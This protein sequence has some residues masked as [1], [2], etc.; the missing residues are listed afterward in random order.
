MR[1]T[2]KLLDTQYRDHRADLREMTNRFVDAIDR[3]SVNYQNFTLKAE[4][5]DEKLVEV[6]EKIL[7]RVGENI[8]VSELID[9]KVDNLYKIILQKKIK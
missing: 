7:K 5:R 9:H 4:A 1:K 8:D 6:V 3:V 2:Y